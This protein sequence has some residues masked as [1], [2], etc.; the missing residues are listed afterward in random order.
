[1]LVRFGF[2][3]KKNRLNRIEPNNFID[4]LFDLFLWEIYELYIILY[5]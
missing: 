2:E 1:M 5:I 4:F 3:E